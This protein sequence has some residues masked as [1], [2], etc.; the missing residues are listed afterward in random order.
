MVV[1]KAIAGVLLIIGLFLL[2]PLL[3]LPSLA[4]PVPASHPRVDTLLVTQLDTVFLPQPNTVVAV[5][6]LAAR[7]T[8]LAPAPL[9]LPP[10][11]TAV[12][13]PRIPT[14]HHNWTFT[15]G[16]MLPDALAGLESDFDP[17]PDVYSTVGRRVHGN[18]FVTMGTTLS[19]RDGKSLSVGLEKRWHR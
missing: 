16:W 19:P 2:I 13:P 12:E 11:V 15:A 3:L 7:V 8:P 10:D 4:D 5:D 6:P 9:S 17:R 18:Y 1:L 14:T